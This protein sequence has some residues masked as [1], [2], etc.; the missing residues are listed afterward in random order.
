MRV[1]VYFNTHKKVWSIRSMNNRFHNNRVVM[2]SSI[3]LLKNCVFRVSETRRKR[4]LLTGQKNV[5]AGV[6]GTL[7]AANNVSFPAFL[8]EIDQISMASFNVP[9]PESIEEVLDTENNGKY[10]V[11]SYNPYKASSFVYHKDG[12]W[13]P[14]YE[15]EMAFLNIN[16]DSDT[17]YK[18]TSMH[19][20]KVN[21]FTP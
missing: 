4:V 20:I 19:V 10:Y 3:A 17:L 15:A 1:F 12:K 2:H 21:Q 18:K 13:H 14:L 5:H 11:A 16:Q 7:V 9:I 6:V 8:N